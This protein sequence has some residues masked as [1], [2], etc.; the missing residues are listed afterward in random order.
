MW[1]SHGNDTASLLSHIS[2]STWLSGQSLRQSYNRNPNRIRWTNFCVF[3]AAEVASKKLNQPAGQVWKQMKM[4][5][6]GAA[7]FCILVTSCSR[8]CIF[9][10][11]HQWNKRNWRHR[12]EY[13]FWKPSFVAS[14]ME[15]LGVLLLL[16]V[17]FWSPSPRSQWVKFNGWNLQLVQKKTP[18]EF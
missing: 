10:P 17:M 15:K 18:K 4:T 13:F 1:I 12:R 2:W 11:H 16:A 6:N 5:R 9:F 3:F 8:S 14:M 7:T